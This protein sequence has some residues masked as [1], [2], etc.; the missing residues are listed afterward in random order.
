MV[1]DVPVGALIL[2]QRGNDDTVHP[3]PRDLVAEMRQLEAHNDDRI[4]AL[5]RE[6]PGSF[7]VDAAAV[8][9]LLAGN[10]VRSAVKRGLVSLRDH[11]LFPARVA[12]RRTR[13]RPR[14]SS[15]TWPTWSTDPDYDG[16]SIGVL[17]LFEEQ[18]ALVN[19]MVTDAIDPAEWEEHAIVVVNPDGFQG[20]ERDV[21]LY[22]LSWDNDVMRMRRSRPARWTPSTSRACST[23]P[24]LGPATRS[25]SSTPLRSTPSR[26][27]GDRPGAIGEW[28]EHCAR[29]KSEGGQRVSRHAGKV[30]SEFEARW[31]T[32][33]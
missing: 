26:M 12:S 24:S 31:L 28:L 8:R 22:S 23:S 2:W 25:T 15:N 11:R 19:E 30:D 18:V 20:D 27:A 13:S 4:I 17:C 21:I 16:A 14:C 10:T 7:S 3:V 1:G 29:F 33:S 9:L 5:V 6:N 32:R